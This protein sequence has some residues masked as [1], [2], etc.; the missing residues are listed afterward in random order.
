MR[1]RRRARRPSRRLLLPEA[2]SGREQWQRVRLIEAVDQHI[3]RLQPTRLEAAEISGADHA[4]KPWKRFQSLEY[5]DFDL[6]APLPP[7]HRGA[8]DVVLCEQVLEHVLEPA[9]AVRNLRALVRPGGRVIVSTPFL[10]RVHELPEWEL[11]DYWR[12]TPHGLRLLLERAGLEVD[13]VGSWG[14]RSVVLGNLD[15]WPAYRRWLPLRNRP[16]MP[17]QVWAFARNPA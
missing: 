9:E 15:F 8:F 16:D 14:N 13:E 10:I 6:C 2:T 11:R 17:V 5:P 4:D 1:A 7:E 3:A 12:W